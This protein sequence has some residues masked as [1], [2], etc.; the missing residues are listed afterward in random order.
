M[1]AFN[2]GRHRISRKGDILERRG[3]FEIVVSIFEQKDAKETKRSVRFQLERSSPS[4]A[5]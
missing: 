3:G 1:N 5:Y 4:R 2:H